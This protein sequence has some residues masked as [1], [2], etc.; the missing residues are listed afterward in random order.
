MAKSDS[1]SGRYEFQGYVIRVDTK[2]DKPVRVHHTSCFLNPLYK[3]TSLDEAMR[4]VEAYRKG[5][6]WAVAACL[7]ATVG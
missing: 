3:T 5:Y 6:Q 1:V 4:W 2:L 7:P